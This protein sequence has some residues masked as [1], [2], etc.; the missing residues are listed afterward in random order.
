[1][2]SAAAQTATQ[3]DAAYQPLDE[4]ADDFEWQ[5]IDFV[6]QILALMGIEDT[7]VFKRNRITTQME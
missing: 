5:I 7:P 6:Q 1:M 4:N 3:I 2:P